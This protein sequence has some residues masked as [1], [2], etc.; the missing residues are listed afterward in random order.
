MHLW[1]EVRVKESCRATIVARSREGLS[2]DPAAFQAQR[3]SHRDHLSLP[4]YCD[5]LMAT[6]LAS[7]WTAHS[8]PATLG[9]ALKVSNRPKP[10]WSFSHRVSLPWSHWRVPLYAFAHYSSWSTLEAVAQRSDA[11]AQAKPSTF[12]QQIR[13][14]C[15]LFSYFH[16]LQSFMT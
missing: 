16:P 11:P 2:S 3:C 6:L 10:R 4:R 13:A 1:P 14:H 5:W 8:G 15:R 12:W 7:I 9:V